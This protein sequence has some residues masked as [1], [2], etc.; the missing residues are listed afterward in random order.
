MKLALKADALQGH[1]LRNRSKHFPN[2]IL[3][4]CCDR[5]ITKCALC[6]SLSFT[7]GLFVSCKEVKD[8]A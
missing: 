4:L 1:L 3:D 8:F 6:N 7:K 5:I 2:L